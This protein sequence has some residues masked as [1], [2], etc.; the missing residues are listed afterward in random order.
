MCV[1]QPLEQRKYGQIQRTRILSCRQKEAQN[2]VITVSGNKT[3]MFMKVAGLK[4]EKL[5]ARTWVLTLLKVA[6]VANV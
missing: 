2:E 1:D 4:N 6:M 5:P 3:V